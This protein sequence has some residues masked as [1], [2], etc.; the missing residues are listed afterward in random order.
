MINEPLKV[1]QIDCH[2][3]AKIDLILNDDSSIL[4]KLLDQTN[5]LRKLCPF[6][7]RLRL[8]FFFRIHQM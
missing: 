7:E 4:E 2:T 8:W 6:F 3:Q 5:K 1:Y